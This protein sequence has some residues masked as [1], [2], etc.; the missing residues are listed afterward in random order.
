MAHGVA[1]IDIDD[2]PSVSLELM[3][4]HPVEVLVVDGVVAA[5]CGGVVVE[6]DGVVAV[7]GIVTAEVVDECRQLPLV[8]HVERLQNVQS[9]ADGLATDYPV[10]VGV[11]VHA[12]AE[13][14]VLYH[15]GVG[16]TAV[17]NGIADHGG[18]R[19][20]RLE[21]LGCDA[22]VLEDGGVAEGV[23]VV[24]V[25]GVVFVA[26]LHRRV[27]AVTGD[28]EA[29]AEDGR[30]ERLRREV[31]LHLANVFLPEE[32]QVLECG[33]LLVVDGDGPHLVQRAVEPF[34]ENG[35]Y[36]PTKNDL[37]NAMPSL[38]K[39]QSDIFIRIFVVFR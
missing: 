33:I 12:D 15:V 21:V 3:L 6:H 29:L 5:Q 9:V 27:E 11:V 26:L 23:E 36:P 2:L 22:I 1:E 8:L 28:A 4:H 14:G 30:L 35:G 37:R 16:Q 31:A 32:L 7:G 39:R 38:T 18:L 25:G 34:G 10:N 13:R 17:G 24:E 20:V 19:V